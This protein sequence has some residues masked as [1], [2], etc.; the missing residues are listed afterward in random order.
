MTAVNV[1]FLDHLNPPYN[2]CAS[3][4]LRRCSCVEQRT[5]QSNLRAA[6]SGAPC[7]VSYAGRE[8]ASVEFI[9]LTTCFCD[10]EDGEL[11]VIRTHASLSRRF[12]LVAHTNEGGL[13]VTQVRGGGRHS[14]EAALQSALSRNCCSRLTASWAS[15]SAPT[16]SSRRS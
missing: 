16:A 12:A 11:C 3:N 8:A 6:G 1:D 13:F 7:S 10:G 15:A 2:A 14:N 4:N 9:G 5:A